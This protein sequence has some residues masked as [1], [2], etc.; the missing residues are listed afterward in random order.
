MKDI[1]E[2]LNILVKYE[3]SEMYAEHDQIYA[4]PEDAND[5]SASDTKRLK[6]LHWFVDSEFGSWTHFT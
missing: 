1:V 5:V 6:K 4:G 2:G 3:G